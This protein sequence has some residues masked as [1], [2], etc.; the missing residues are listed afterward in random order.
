MLCQF[1]LGLKY[2]WYLQ[3]STVTVLH[4]TGGNSDMFVIGPGAY[5]FLGVL[6]SSQKR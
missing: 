2:S 1:K 4:V 5:V 6:F 3:E